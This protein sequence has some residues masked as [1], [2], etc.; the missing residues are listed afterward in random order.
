P[1]GFTDSGGGGFSYTAPLGVTGIIQFA[2]SIHTSTVDSLAAKVTIDVQPAVIVVPPTCTLSAAPTTI[3]KGQLSTLTWTTTNKPT[4]ATIDHGIGGV[5]PAGGS[6]S[7]SPV[8]TTTYTMTVL[9]TAGSNQCSAQVTVILPAPLFTITD[10]GTLAGAANSIGN[11][12]N[13]SGQ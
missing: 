6:T 5:N 11:S 2:Y 3:N 10:L 12:V 8:V 9:N 13:N 4:S 1:Q 7:V